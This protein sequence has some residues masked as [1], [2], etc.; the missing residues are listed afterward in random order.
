MSP[1]SATIAFSFLPRSSDTRPSARHNDGKGREPREN[2][3]G[4][5]R[6]GRWLWWWWPAVLQTRVDEAVCC[7]GGPYTSQLYSQ[8][9]VCH[10]S[11][12]NQFTSASVLLIRTDKDIQISLHACAPTAMHF[13]HINSRFYDASSVQDNNK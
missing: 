4:R 10:I 2:V 9:S 6:D 5:L 13:I 3:L 7:M 12:H 8:V 1:S 11:N